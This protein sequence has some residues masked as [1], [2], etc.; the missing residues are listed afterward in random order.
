MRLNQFIAGCFG[1]VGF[2]VSI[3]A[4]LYANNTFDAILTRAILATIACYVIGLLVGLMG[5]AAATEQ[6][7]RIADIVAQE[8]AEEEAKRLSDEQAADAEQAATEQA[9]TVAAAP[10]EAEPT[11]ISQ[12]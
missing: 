1:T 6:A 2:V 10:S 9:A 12:A 7:Q 8:D 5:Q 3:L 11:T 4:G